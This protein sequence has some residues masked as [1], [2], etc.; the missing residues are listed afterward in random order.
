MDLAFSQIRYL[1]FCEALESANVPQMLAVSVGLVLPQIMKQWDVKYPSMLIAALYA[2]ALV[3]A[4]VCGYAVDYV[5]RKIVWQISLFVVSIFT[6]IAASSPNF[7]ALAVFIGFQTV[8]AG[9][10]RKH[11]VRLLELSTDKR[12]LPLT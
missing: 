8:G 4:V 10:N 6:M 2:G 7:A 11:L 9:G 5:G 3:G 12:K 1:L